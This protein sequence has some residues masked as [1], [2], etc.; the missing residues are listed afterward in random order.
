[1]VCKKVTKA[2]LR[3]MLNRLDMDILAFISVVHS[4]PHLQPP[5][6]VSMPMVRTTCT[7]SQPESRRNC[8]GGTVQQTIVIFEYVGQT[9]GTFLYKE[10]Y[11]MND[12]CRHEKRCGRT[13]R[14]R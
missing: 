5:S 2:G 3:S 4:E 7:R 14:L 11:E 8:T 10:H 13:L 9:T 12:D 6:R 1:M